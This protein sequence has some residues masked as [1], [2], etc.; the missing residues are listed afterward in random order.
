MTTMD[1]EAMVKEK[2]QRPINNTEKQKRKRKQV[3][4]DYEDKNTKAGM[5]VAR[6]ASK[7]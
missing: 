5:K 2:Y 4:G 1:R 3:M 6:D 7:E